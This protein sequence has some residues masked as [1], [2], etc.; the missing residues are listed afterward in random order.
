M[1]DFKKML[2]SQMGTLETEP[3]I[4]E[5]AESLRKLP[6]FR[7][8]D[9]QEYT[10]ILDN[11]IKTLRESYGQSYVVESNKKHE[12]WFESYYKD[13]GIT[14]W[15]RYV[16]YL[17]NFK[18][19]SPAVITGMRENLFKII[20]FAGN[21]NGDNFKRKGLIIGDVQ[22]GKTANYV[23]LMNLATDAKYKLIIVLTGTTNTLREQTQ[24]R[25][26]EGLGISKSSQGV[27]NIKNHDYNA[28]VNMEPIYLTSRQSDFKASSRR[29]FQL[30]IETT[31]VPIVIVT[32][33]NVTALKN[34]YD[35][36]T[37]YSKRN[38]ADDHINSSI[39][40]IDDEADFASVNTKSDDENP[41]AINSKI[42]DILELF[43]RSSYIGFTATPYAN[44]FINPDSNEEMYG[45]DL[46][47]KDYIYVLGESSEYLGVQNIFGPDATHSYIVTDIN[48]EEVETYLP[49]KHK[50]DYS[51]TELSPSMKDAIH[52]FF[53]G[54]VI[55]DLR[56][57][58][59]KHRS[60]LFNI[61]RYTDMH[62]QI[63]RVVSQYVDDVKKDIRLFGKLPLKEALDRPR[64]AEIKNCYE[65]HYGKLCQVY[66]FEEILKN[67]NEAIYRIS[68][69]I[70]NKD[71]KELNYLNNEVEGERVIVIGG[72]ALSRGLTLE[73]L[74]ISYYYRNS[75]MYD[76]LLQMG[77][78]FGYRPNYSDL[79]R[80]FMTEDVKIDFEFIAMATS[81][82][83]DDLLMNSKRGLTPK[84]F[85]I[86]VRSGQTG[87]IITARNKMR[88]GQQIT[89][90]ID[91]SKD[92][93]ETKALSISNRD[94][95][96]SNYNLICSL[97]KEHKDKLSKHMDPN[98][99]NVIYGLKDVDKISI[100]YFI[101]QYLPSNGSKFD[102][103]L[104]T[105]WLKIN[106]NKVLDRW[107]VVFING[108]EKSNFDYGFGITGSVSKRTLV[109]SKEMDG[110]YKLG[111]SRL[112]SPSDGKYGLS[113]EMLKKVKD[114]YQKS[115]TTISQKKYFEKEFN[116][117]PVI[118]VYSILP[119]IHED[120]DPI[121]A[122]YIPLLS[123]GIPEIG[124]D[125]SIPVTYTVNTIYKDI[126][127]MELEE[128]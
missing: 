7:N 17:S 5:L 67:M 64:I 28:F 78:W 54:N 32:K 103:N 91:F 52:L 20:D 87:L 105:N 96:Q 37:D 93:I 10:S 29:N 36:L 56:G 99:E 6:M 35:W 43:T 41:T 111:N 114:M 121:V 38:A 98:S 74:M 80:I 42:R 119:F 63:K 117:K 16:D 109:M 55:R 49:L 84:E 19:F 120:R 102:S 128:E 12:V 85:G 68:V 51:F 112:G 72:F 2:Y 122:E 71:N 22:S 104:I 88:S 125:K 123:V 53:I 13:L 118:L 4:I 27:S 95:N 33:K 47:P 108:S 66:P 124:S 110:I 107:D 46:F 45:Q 77:R 31:K 21:P 23:G 48:E 92:I 60:M 127:N 24:I 30:S 9:E 44:I 106:S 61:S 76:S 3:Q 39:L 34:I 62:S 115:E 50:K 73:G 116:H 25:I 18:G 86:K 40:L 14:R 59:T 81:E 100:I 57:D 83:K 69:A 26:E 75:V 97:V 126:E 90:H 89:T 11:S 58:L 113:S 101:S 82:L 94:I 70:V 15:D 8:I 1:Y 65:V 79:C